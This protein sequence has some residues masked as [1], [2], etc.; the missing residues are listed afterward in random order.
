MKY[1]SFPQKIKLILLS[2]VIGG[3]FFYLF[4]H[5]ASTFFAR[6]PAYKKLIKEHQDVPVTS[7][8]QILSKRFPHSPSILRD[9]EK[10]NQKQTFFDKSEIGSIRE[11]LSLA[12]NKLS[13]RKETVDAFR[14]FRGVWK[15]EDRSVLISRDSIKH[16]KE[17]GLN[18]QYLEF[19]GPKGTS[20]YGLNSLKDD[21]TFVFS[22]IVDGNLSEVFERVGVMINSKKIVWLTKIL[23]QSKKDRYRISI[24]QVMDGLLNVKSVDIDFKEKIGKID[25]V[26]F[27]THQ[28]VRA[29]A[30]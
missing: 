20:A 23:N 24:D 26:N 17:H 4:K 6:H 10:I 25:K 11:A 28:F 12:S 18:L 22:K 15:G 16:S 7:R 29:S 14:S 9:L 30:N 5:R 13:R 27:S 3:A 19:R 2:L 21:S 1:Y 8:K